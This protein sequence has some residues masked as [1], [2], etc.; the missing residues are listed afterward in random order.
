MKKKDFAPVH[1]G[2]ILLE[3]FLRPMG[4]SAGKLAKLINVD[5][6]RTSDIV[7]GRR[8]ITADTALRLGY[9]FNIS[10]GFWL[11]LQKRYDLECAEDKMGQTIRNKVRPIP[12]SSIDGKFFTARSGLNLKGRD[13]PQVPA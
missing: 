12:R 8:D 7:H 9:L 4:L 11:N 2:E 5:R 1:P 3:D 13:L 6:R 10:P